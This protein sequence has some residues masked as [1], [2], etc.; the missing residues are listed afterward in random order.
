MN[1][2]KNFAHACESF[3]S[4]MEDDI[5]IGCVDYSAMLGN[6]PDFH[7]EGLVITD[8]LWTGNDF[9]DGAQQLPEQYH[10]DEVYHQVMDIPQTSTSSLHYELLG[11][12]LDPHCKS[13]LNSAFR[14]YRKESTK[15]VQLYLVP[16]VGQKSVKRCFD[17]LRRT[18]KNSRDKS[19]W[20][21]NDGLVE[22][23]YA[24]THKLAERNRRT[25]LTQQFLALRSLVPH[26]SKKVDK[27][28]TLS[29]AIM[30]LNRQKL[31]IQELEQQNQSLTNA[32]R[33]NSMS[34]ACSSLSYGCA[35]NSRRDAFMHCICEE[36]DVLVEKT[37]IPDE[38]IIEVTL[39]KVASNCPHMD[40]IATVDKCLRKME[41]KVVRIQWRELGSANQLIEGTIRR[42]AKGERWESRQ[43]KSAVKHALT[44]S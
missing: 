34:E 1:M 24:F 14:N 12:N 41:L 13:K 4:L 32:V 42:K 16:A 28:S 26:N 38:A 8:R 3:C 18:Y 33:E 27:S 6:S 20:E 17:F 25:K 37:S 7:R 43:I 30:E 36:V 21:A 23:S 44:G 35:A 31:R 29:N 22:E 10:I 39:K 40:A 9:T 5:F 15:E 2:E 19:S 11:N